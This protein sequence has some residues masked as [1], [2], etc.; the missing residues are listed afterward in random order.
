MSERKVRKQDMSTR[1]KA[2]AACWCWANAFRDER[3][4]QIKR[5]KKTV[6][7]RAK[8]RCNLYREAF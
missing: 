4:R 7:H 6:E 1:N 2:W 5:L 8:E 3:K